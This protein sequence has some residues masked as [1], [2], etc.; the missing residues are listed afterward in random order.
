[1]AVQ[2][3][4]DRHSKAARCGAQHVSDEAAAAAALMPG[5]APPVRKP[6]ASE[7][8]RQ[9][10]FERRQARYEE[11]ACLRAAGASISRIAALLGAERK[12]VRRWLRLGQAPLWRHPRRGS[13]PDAHETFLDRRWTEGC[14]NAAQLWRELVG[15]GLTGRAEIV[16]S[17]AGR[18]RK[19]EPDIA[20][21]VTSAQASM[22]QPP[23][24]RQ[25]ARLLMADSNELPAPEQGCV[26]HLLREAPR[27][28]EAVAVT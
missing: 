4:A 26:A 10:S 8:R 18:R 3:L 5:P 20:M 14:R 25:T 13:M 21:R 28:A 15:L 16:R 9:A 24:G 1:M 17:W 23:L 2:A 22:T 11:V 12:T 27:L 6:T 19:G 7:R